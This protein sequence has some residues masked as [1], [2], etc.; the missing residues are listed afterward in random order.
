MNR[1][2]DT[3][4]SI[5]RLIVDQPAPGAWNMAV[6]EALLAD[7]I[8][9][10]VATLRLYEWSHPTIS[11]GYF[12]KYDDRLQHGASQNAAV[13]RRQSGG[14]A[15]LHDRELTYSLA[16]PSTHPRA[17]QA[18]YLYTAIHNAVIDVLTPLLAPTAT[19]WKLI[20][21]GCEECTAES[22]VE[23]PFLCFQRRA[24]GDLLL[25]PMGIRPEGPVSP[26]V[27]ILGS[28]QRRRQ[29]AILQHGSLLFE[30]SPA[31]PELPGVYNLTGIRLTADDV[32]VTLANTV[33]RALRIDLE[34]SKL[35]EDRR[36]L[37]AELESRKYGVLEWT[38]RH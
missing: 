11:L 19:G 16:L 37:A 30:T 8:E 14:G 18:E 4:T 10:G 3:S 35:P 6:D 13:V 5:C 15:I 27:K 17:R 22:S 25:A 21:R 1:S 33:S 31:A 36:V 29:G 20:L 34:E 7:A 23:E 2:C 28:A 26:G 9:N 32:S 24:A 38:K 12:Q